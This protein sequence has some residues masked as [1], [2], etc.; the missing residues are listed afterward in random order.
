M[1]QDDIDRNV[2]AETTRLG[3][4][5]RKEARYAFACCTSQG[6]AHEMCTQIIIFE[7]KGLLV[8]GRFE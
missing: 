6:V 1:E 8:V 2:I 5:D 4:G 3:A 7:R